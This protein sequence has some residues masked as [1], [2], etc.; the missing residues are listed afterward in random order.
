M[1]LELQ[2]RHQN[3]AIGTVFL[4]DK[5]K[6][7]EHEFSCTGMSWSGAET[8]EEAVEHIVSEYLLWKRNHHE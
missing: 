2:V 8:I 5:G 4:D 6:V 1:S 3:V 7:Y